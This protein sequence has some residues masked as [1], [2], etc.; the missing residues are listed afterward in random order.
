MILLCCCLFCATGIEWLHL[1]DNLLIHPVNVVCLLVYTFVFTI[2]A[3]DC[4]GTC[5]HLQCM[6]TALLWIVKNVFTL[7]AL[8]TFLFTILFTIIVCLHVY[9]FTLVYCCRYYEWRWR[10]GDEGKNVVSYP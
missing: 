10:E 6:F 1:G 4:S 9:M 7:L 8:R 5:L 3:V 2:V